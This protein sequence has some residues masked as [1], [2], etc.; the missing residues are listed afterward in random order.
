MAPRLG[1][2]GLTKSPRAEARKEG[3]LWLN[4][5]VSPGWAAG[6]GHIMEDSALGLHSQ[7]QEEALRA[8]EKREA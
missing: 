3:H 2:E 8:S 7:S 1:H 5:E 4:D 6:L